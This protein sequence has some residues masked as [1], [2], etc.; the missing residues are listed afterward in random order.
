MVTYPIPFLKCALLFIFKKY[1]YQVNLFMFKLL[2]KTVLLTSIQVLFF[3]LWDTD[4]LISGNQLLPP[5]INFSVFQSGRSPLSTWCMNIC[6][7]GGLENK[8]WSFSFVMKTRLLKAA[9]KVQ[10]VQT[11]FFTPWCC[12]AFNCYELSLLEVIFE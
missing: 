3:D 10:T 11:F 2:F 12:S 4:K 8:K 9:I 1:M 5:F 6:R 7:S